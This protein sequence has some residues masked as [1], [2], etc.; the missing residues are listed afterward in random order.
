MIEVQIDPKAIEVPRNTSSKAVDR[1]QQS[2]FEVGSRNSTLTRIG[3][4]VRD[5]GLEENEIARVLSAINEHKCSQPLP[6]MDIKK[7][8]KSVSRYTPTSKPHDL[9]DRG[10][11]YRL[12]DHYEEQLLYASQAK[13]AYCY[14]GICWEEHEAGWLKEVQS[15]KEIA[16]VDLGPMISVCKLLLRFLPDPKDSTVA[17]SIRNKVVLAQKFIESLGSAS[18]IQNAEKL[19]RCQVDVRID[20]FDKGIYLFNLPNGT[21]NLNTGQIGSHNSED[22]ITHLAGIDYDPSAKC[23]RFKK[24]IH[25]ISLG[26][27]ELIRLFQV[28]AGYCL[29][30]DVREQIFFLFIGTGGNG[31]S[32]LVEVLAE[33]LGS[34]ACT[35]APGLLVEKRHD[36]HPTEIY[37]LKGR[38]LIICSETNDGS[39]FNAD[40]L[41]KLTGDGTLKA[42]PMRGDFVEFP[43]YGK[44]VLLTNNL[45]RIT[46][47]DRGI[48]R[49]IFPISFDAIFEGDRKDKHLKDKL[50]KELPGILN[51]AVEGFK[52]FLQEGFKLPASS[53]KLLMQ[54][55][56]QEDVLL[57]FTDAWLHP[58][59]GIK[60]AL[61]EVLKAYR[62]V[63]QTEGHIVLFNSTMR[64][65]NAL[66]DRGFEVG[67]IPPAGWKGPEK[68]EQRQS[69]VWGIKLKYESGVNDG[70]V[71]EFRGSN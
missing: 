54:Y 1:F 41:K 18:R 53:K 34:Y 22:R 37:D 36:E 10:N 25:E 28:M 68:G 61:T 7:I 11:A 6:L 43:M 47:R 21:L 9:D 63:C 64:L 58:Q 71:I 38:R 55:R 24:F 62:R 29:S 50:L 20:E 30:G 67:K 19:L 3:G 45:P 17:S 70:E 56:D 31:K 69:Q 12:R 48:W 60:T 33:L 65:G 39:K 2:D 8:A 27:P 14:S 51:W 46:G 16:K 26:D 52:L 35:A 23:D 44:I 66:K 57:D 4:M 59:E 40:K 32:V 5:V 15:L 42:R 49:R 13:R